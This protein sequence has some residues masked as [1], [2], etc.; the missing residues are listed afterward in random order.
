MFLPC[1]GPSFLKSGLTRFT[2]T[3]SSPDTMRSSLMLSSLLTRSAIASRVARWVSSVTGTIS[4]R[5]GW[6]TLMFIFLRRA[7]AIEVMS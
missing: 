5:S 7:S 2:M 1:F 3:L 4:V 6:R